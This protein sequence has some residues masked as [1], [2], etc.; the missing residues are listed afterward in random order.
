MGREESGSGMVEDHIEMFIRYLLE[1][2]K[3]NKKET[4]INLNL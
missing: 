4:I 1:P 3:I 2:P